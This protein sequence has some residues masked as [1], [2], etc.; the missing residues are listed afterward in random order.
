MGPNLVVTIPF[1]KLDPSLLV[2]KGVFPQLTTYVDAAERIISSYRK[3]AVVPVR[4]VWP[5]T[6]S[7]VEHLFDQDLGNVSKSQIKTVKHNYKQI[8][9]KWPEWTL[10]AFAVA[11]G[12]PDLFKDLSPDPPP[13]VTIAPSEQVASAMP[14]AVQFL[15][16]A[17]A[18]DFD[19]GR[20]IE[21]PIVDNVD[22]VEIIIDK[23][24]KL[25]LHFHKGNGDLS[26]TP[27]IVECTAF[28]PEENLL[29]N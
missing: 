6:K 17:M 15:R 4:F 11:A 8:A 1:G 9:E 3:G 7:C 26:I 29:Q 22:K 5:D 2:A 13:K 28:L 18:L 20:D 12:M 25:E 21:Q 10:S 27:I 14:M 16:I 19:R 23:S 24:G